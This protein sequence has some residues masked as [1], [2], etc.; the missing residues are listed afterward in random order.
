MRVRACRLRTAIMLDQILWSVGSVPG[1][2]GP[3]NL[4]QLVQI[5]PKG[6]HRL[7]HRSYGHGRSPSW[8]QPTASTTRN[9]EKYSGNYS[10]LPDFHRF[11]AAWRAIS[12]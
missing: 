11:S 5:A 6:I 1:V 3:Q 10:Y 12:R 9:Q 8:N 7:V 4:V 2:A